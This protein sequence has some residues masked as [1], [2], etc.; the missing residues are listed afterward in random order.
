MSVP[1]SS[2]SSSSSSLSL[3]NQSAFH[4]DRGRGTSEHG[5]T[6]RGKGETRR[7]RETASLSAA[8]YPAAA[9]GAASALFRML[10]F[11]AASTVALGF[12]GWAESFFA[13][14]SPSYMEE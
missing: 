3:G 6:K 5:W 13:A 1:S 2:L 4:A 7:E 11:G 8:A 12:V 10:F 14:S 9:V